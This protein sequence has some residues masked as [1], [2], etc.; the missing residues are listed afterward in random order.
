MSRRIGSPETEKTRPTAA[1]EPV[2][3]RTYQPSAALNTKIPLVP[4]S[5]DTMK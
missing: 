4:H 1:A 2:T 5:I 3:P